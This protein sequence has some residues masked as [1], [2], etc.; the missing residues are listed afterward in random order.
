MREDGAD[1][2]GTLIYTD[3]PTG[4]SEGLTIL[5]ISIRLFYLKVPQK[6]KKF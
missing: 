6:K 4:L 1:S 2:V 5:D 3:F